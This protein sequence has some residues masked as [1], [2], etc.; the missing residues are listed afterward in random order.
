METTRQLSLEA[1][2]T[3]TQST[4]YR[5]QSKVW[6]L[7]LLAALL[8][9]ILTKNPIYLLIII[10]A[11]G[12]NY[13]TLDT[14]SPTVQGWRAFLY[15]GLV[16][17]LISTAFNIL[18]VRAGMTHLFTLPELNWNVTTKTGQ[19]T[20]MQLGGKITLESL[21]Y[22]L[23]TGLALMAILL[24]FATFNTQVDHYQL[25]RSTPRFL[26]QSAIVMS[27]AIT[28]IPH[29]V[30]AQREIREA[31][32]LRGHRF[33]RIRDLL[34]LFVTL[35]AEGLER[36]LTLAESMEARGFSSLPGGRR[37]S[38]HLFMKG[39]IA[40][41]LLLLAGGALAW[42]YAT[43][44]TIGGIAILAGGILLVVSLWLVGRNVQRSRYHRTIWR[45]QD[46]M[47]TI[48]S[49]LTLLVI[50]AIWLTNPSVF[51]FYPYPRLTWPPFWPLVG[52]TLLLLAAPAVINR[53]LQE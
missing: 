38:T 10:L 39:L 53:L 12:V 40:L 21:I 9:A 22:G 5:Y 3:A 20:V 26:Y 6:V 51:V 34:P 14:K 50:L 25:L 35:L 24:I 41:A 1:T 33:R 28:F 43:I 8:P 2:E 42:N 48:T 23:S 31:Q 18:F 19:I 52:A 44:K 16:L 11:V 47:L 30:I 4:S 27:I 32:T 37:T 17:V 15:F 36:S 46:T 45:K 29:M 49:I 13:T 7:W